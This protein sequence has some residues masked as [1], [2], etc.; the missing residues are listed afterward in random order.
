MAIQI[1]M[2]KFQSRNDVL[3]KYLESVYKNTFNN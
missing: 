3:R 1:E 2:F